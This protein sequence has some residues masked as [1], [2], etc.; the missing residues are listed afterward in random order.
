MKEGKNKQILHTCTDK[1][2]VCASYSHCCQPV[3]KP[4]ALARM[5]RALSDT[6]SQYEQTPE[7][8]VGG[9]K[10]AVYPV[11]RVLNDAGQAK[12]AISS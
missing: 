12:L 4:I 6:A 10:I 8:R 2:C 1:C 7:L 5:A 11:L 9:Q 3:K